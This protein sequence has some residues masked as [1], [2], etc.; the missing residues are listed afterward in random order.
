[1][2]PWICGDC[3][4]TTT[5]GDN[6]AVAMSE[7][8]TYRK[9]DHDAYA[10]SREPD[11]FW[12]QIRRTVHGVPVSDDQ[13]ALIVDTIREALRLE[14]DDAL[15]DIA[16]GNGA[17]SQLLFGSCARYLG[18]DLSE[19]LISV[20]KENFE[21]SPN[22]EFLHYGASEYLRWESDPKRFSKVLCYGSFSYFPDAVAVESL[23]ALFD[24]F[25]NVESVFIGN[26]PDKDRAEEFYK[27]EPNAKE[28][29]DCH[30]QIG[31]WRTQD[32]LTR[33]ASGAGWQ[34]KLSAM[35]RD[36]YS[37][38]YRYDALLYR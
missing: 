16:C 1:M 27:K 38:Y 29:A 14:P 36:F 22:Y 37:S 30:S 2:N 33:L 11:D 12:G 19:H 28:L 20:A 25:T 6:G 13:I 23:H 17:L 5:F 15:L 31:I 21:K 35:P 18:V 8:E 24:K 9:F 7:D 10:R 32:E 3:Y 4:E 26:L 34:V